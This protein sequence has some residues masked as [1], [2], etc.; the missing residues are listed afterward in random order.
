MADALLIEWEQVLVDVRLPREQAIAQAERRQSSTRGAADDTE[1]ELIALDAER[2][3]QHALSLG[4]TLRAGVREFLEAAQQIGPVLI[5]TRAPRETTE[6]MLRVTELDACIAGVMCA[7]DRAASGDSAQALYRRAAVVIAE[8]RRLSVHR[9]IVLADKLNQLQ[10]AMHAGF[11]V[12]AV[13]APSHE[14]LE[15][16]GAV[17]AIDGLQLSALDMLAGLTPGSGHP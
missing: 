13:Q 3:V 10:E 14:A 12:V 8:R 15:A 5:V 1:R 2:H 4:V 11:R 17:D 6:A 16:H 7:N 9:S